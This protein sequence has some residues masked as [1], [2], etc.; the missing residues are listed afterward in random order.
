VWYTAAVRIRAITGVALLA[1]ATLAA[2]PVAAEDLGAFG[3]CLT[4]AHATLY[5]ASWCPHTA[6]QRDLLGDAMDEVTYVE[7]SVGGTRHS[8]PDCNEADVHNYPTW[9]FGDGSRVK[10]V[11]SLAKLAGRTGCRLSSEERPAAN[12]R[13]VGRALRDRTIPGGPRIIDV[14]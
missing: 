8:T 13:P 12:S 10:G 7:C 9:V 14:R 4:R 3:R 11:M 5:G 2:A 1:G 6:E